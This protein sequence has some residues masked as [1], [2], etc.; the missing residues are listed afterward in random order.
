[1]SEVDDIDRNIVLLEAH[2]HVLEVILISFQ[3]VADEDD[4]SLPL[5][6]VLPVLEGELGD[7]D[8]LEAVGVA[9]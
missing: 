9:V 8:C 1:M 7:L 5:R 4:D 2:S 6:L 3:R